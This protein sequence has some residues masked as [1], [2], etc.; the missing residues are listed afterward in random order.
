MLNQRKR[1]QSGRTIGIA[2]DP[3]GPSALKKWYLWGMQFKQD[4]EATFILLVKPFDK[5]PFFRISTGRLR[6][7]CSANHGL[8]NQRMRRRQSGRT[9]GIANDPLGPSALKKWHLWM[10]QFK[11]DVE[12]TFILLVKP[13]DNRPFFRIST[14]RLRLPCSIIHELMNQ[15]KR[16][17]SGR[18]SKEVAFIG[19]AIHTGCGGH[20]HPAG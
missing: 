11:Q 2:N 9:I 14:G 4:V 12:A 7:P 13:F 18:F 16:K 17:L 5:R 10:M 20:L 15:R 19:D 1:K 3:Q 6:L 8:L